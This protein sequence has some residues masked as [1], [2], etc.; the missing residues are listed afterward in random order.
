MV[1]WK[2][3][4]RE[5]KPEEMRGLGALQQFTTYISTSILSEFCTMGTFQ[6]SLCGSLM[7]KNKTKQILSW[8][9]SVMNDKNFYDNCIVPIGN[10]IV[11]IIIYLLALV[12]FFVCAKVLC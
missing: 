11:L 4:G 5:E 12:Q 10:V 3:S 1:T 9:C 6:A 2:D 8:E 7:I